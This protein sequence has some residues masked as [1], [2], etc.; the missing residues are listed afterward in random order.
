MIQDESEDDAIAHYRFQKRHFQEVA[1][2]IW[3]RVQE[4]LVG[5]KVAATYDSGNYSAPYES[6]FLM[7]LLRFSRLRTKAYQAQDGDLLWL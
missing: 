1:D 2:K 3:P 5:D 6:L 4:C 7:V